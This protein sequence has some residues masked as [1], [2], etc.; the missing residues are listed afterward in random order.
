MEE[1]NLLSQHK[2]ATEPS[3]L[4]PAI[5]LAVHYFGTPS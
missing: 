2:L 5:A 1:L 4:S 3:D